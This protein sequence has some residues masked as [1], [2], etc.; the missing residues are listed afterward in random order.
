MRKL[1]YI[2]GPM[3]LGSMAHNIR[4][5]WEAAERLID[6]G[7]SP[8][9]PQNNFFREIMAKQRSHAEWLDIDKPLV[10]ASSAILR[11]PGESKGADQEVRWAFENHIPVF[12]SIEDLL[13]H[14][15]QEKR[16]AVA[17]VEVGR[18]PSPAGAEADC[19]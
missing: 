10:L 15:R 4:M 6:E 13:A 9:V 2:A 3:A 1:I 17:A 11:L 12:Q 8:I 5:A 16:I 18:K 19:G 14:F 7:F